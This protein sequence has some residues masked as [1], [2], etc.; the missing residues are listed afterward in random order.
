MKAFMNFKYKNKGL[1]Y[2]GQTLF[3]YLWEPVIDGQPI[4]LSKEGDDVV[5]G[6]LALRFIKDDDTQNWPS[7]FPPKQGKEF[8][9]VFPLGDNPKVI[10]VATNAVDAFPIDERAFRRLVLLVAES[11]NSGIKE[12][13]NGPVMTITQY[14]KKYNSILNSSYKTL[15][16]RSVNEWAHLDLQ[17]EEPA[18][19]KHLF[20]E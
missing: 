19:T 20:A 15:M 3:G 13:E 4:Y 10:C 18:I 14:A 7:M 1:K 16:K 9:T 5:N 6:Y 8:I 12:D 11:Q 2:T 17:T